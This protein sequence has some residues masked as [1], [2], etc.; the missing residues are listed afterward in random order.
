MF[1]DGNQD[2]AWRLTPDVV[3]SWHWTTVCGDQDQKYGLSGHQGII[4]S[5]AVTDGRKGSVLVDPEA[6][7][8]MMYENGKQY[9]L[10]RNPRHD[11]T[12]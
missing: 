1:Y 12:S 9:T 11:P 10:V 3:G 7:S 6:T 5:V 8:Q 2:W 4:Q